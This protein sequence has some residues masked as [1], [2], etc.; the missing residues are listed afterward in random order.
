MTDRTR[1]ERLAEQDFSPWE[2]RL[3]IMAA[4]IV[5]GEVVIDV[6]AGSRA[7]RGLISPDCLYLPLDCVETS[8]IFYDFD[9]RGS[10]P[11]LKA[12]TAVMSGILEYLYGPRHALATV[13]KWA[14]RILLSYAVAS[15]NIEDRV[16]NGWVSH[17][18]RAELD[19]VFD[20][21]DLKAVEF[22]VWQEQSLFEA[23]RKEF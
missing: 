20:D 4:R 5:P 6:G 22:G 1:W 16:K 10:P 2:E 21:T 9:S 11:C 23:V 3:K 18:T 15:G 14:P 8:P 7:L 12:D 17:M 19:V 13:A